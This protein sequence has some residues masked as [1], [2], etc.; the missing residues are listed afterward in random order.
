MLFIYSVV[1]VCCC[2]TSFIKL[3]RNFSR[4]NCFQCVILE[5]LI[6]DYAVWILLII[7]GQ[8]VTY[9]C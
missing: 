5:P 8:T 4:L 6:A 3:G 2:V 1:L 7:E 9:S